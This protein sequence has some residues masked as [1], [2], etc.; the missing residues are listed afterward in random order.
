MVMITIRWTMNDFLGHVEVKLDK[1]V[2]M[3]EEA[4][5]HPI[6]LPFTLREFHGKPLP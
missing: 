5:N 3:A 1:L 4:K 2:L 6:R